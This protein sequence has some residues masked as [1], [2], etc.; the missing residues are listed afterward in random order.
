MA[1]IYVNNLFVIVNGPSWTEAEAEAAKLGGLLTSI[2][3][4]QEKA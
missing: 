3:S 2:G 4:I 1:S